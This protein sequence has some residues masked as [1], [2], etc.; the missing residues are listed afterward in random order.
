MKAMGLATEPPQPHLDAALPL[1][2]WPVL[3]LLVRAGCYAALAACANRFEF[4]PAL[5]LGL[6]VGDFSATVANVTWQFRDGKVIAF[7]ELAVLALVYW[8]FVG[9]ID[10]PDEPALR[11]ILGLAAF[12]VF[13]T[14]VGGSVL[15]RL[16]PN[17][18]EFG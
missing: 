9:R 18:H 6:L 17:E 14:R 8:C 13:T 1:L 7:A 2:G 11:A 3:G 5:C 16:G 12:G 4:G 10:W 15:T